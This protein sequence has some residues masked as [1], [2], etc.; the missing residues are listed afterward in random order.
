MCVFCIPEAFPGLARRAVLLIPPGPPVPPRLP[1]YTSHPPL[2]HLQSTLAK[3]FANVDSTTLTENSNPLAATLTRNGGGA[4][5]FRPQSLSTCYS[6]SVISSEARNL[7]AVPFRHPF[8]LAEVAGSLVT[9]LRTGTQTRHARVAATPFSSCASAR[10]PSHRGGGGRATLHHFKFYFKSSRSLLRA[11][12]CHGGMSVVADGAEGSLRM[13]LRCAPRAIR[14][15]IWPVR[16]AARKESTPQ[17]TMSPA[18]STTPAKMKK[19]IMSPNVPELEKGSSL[20][21]G[22]FWL[23]DLDSNQDS[24]IQSLES[25]RLDDLPAEGRKKNEP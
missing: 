21:H 20:L 24:Q 1:L 11:G 25:Y 23:G 7:S 8:T 19:I 14:M 15:S 4:R 10:F 18:S 6:L 3:P 9:V 22:K 2:S 5:L 12:V 13:A 16:R 17:V